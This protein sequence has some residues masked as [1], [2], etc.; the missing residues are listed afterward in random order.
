VS[1]ILPE[2]KHEGAM[3]DE[4]GGD[5]DLITALF[6]N[7][8]GVIHDDHDSQVESHLHK[9]MDACLCELEPEDFH[10]PMLDILL[11][12]L[13]DAAER[14]NPRAYSLAKQLFS[15]CFELLQK[16]VSAY[17]R[18][19]LEDK[20]GVADASEVKDHVHGV[21]RELHT[22]HADYL[23]YIF[24][25]LMDD[26]TSHDAERRRQTVVVMGQLF[27]SRHANY[28]M[29]Y[30]QVRDAFSLSLSLCVCLS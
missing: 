26:L 19:M 2:L 24:P 4:D 23:L 21:I 28:F 6:S 30:A 9:V 16:P 3:G 5:G 1:A 13:T 8:L 7:L 22:V 25:A 15:S 29:D 11:L 14:E 12:P 27:L 18:G 17:L 20:A 10:G